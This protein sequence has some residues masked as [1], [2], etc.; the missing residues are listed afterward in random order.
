MVARTHLFFLR[1]LCFLDDSWPAL[2]FRQNF[3]HVFL[4]VV[5]PAFNRPLVNMV[6]ARRF[7]IVTAVSVTASWVGEGSKCQGSYARE[8][9]L[10]H[11]F[12]VG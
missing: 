3:Q 12:S 9:K 4:I 1:L 2:Y 10:F 11:G 8:G 7:I 5:C 6:L